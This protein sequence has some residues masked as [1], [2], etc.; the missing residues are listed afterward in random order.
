MIQAHISQSFLEDLATNAE[1]ECF[2]PLLKVTL[3]A[4]A[5]PI[6]ML[7]ECGTVMLVNTA[8]RTMAAMGGR[9][10]RGCHRGESYLAF[11]RTLADEI[12]GGLL[13]DGMRRLIGGRQ[14]SLEATCEVKRSGVRRMLRIQVHRVEQEMPARFVATHR[15]LEPPAMAEEVEERIAAA[16]AKERERL[17][18]ELHDSVGQHLV[19]LGLG[20]TQ[21]RRAAADHPELTAVIGEMAESLREAHKEVRTLSYVMYPPPREEGGFGAEAVSE[22]VTGFARRAGLAASV[23]VKG[24]P[25]ELDRSRELAL[26]RVLQEALVNIHRHARAG[27]VRV[28]LYRRGGKVRLT[29][30]DDGA[31]FGGDE[32]AGSPRSG[33]GLTAMHARMALLGGDLRI[34]SGPGGTTLTAELPLAPASPNRP[35]G[36]GNTTPPC[37]TLQ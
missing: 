31:G 22:F 6:A 19:C 28:Q 14:D 1:R 32:G 12:S 13:K 24:F 20:L 17:A 4:L 25:C 2:D 9:D 15:E 11:C 35:L 26:F 7:D 30:K 5:V 29:V 36:L 37:T 23:E 21:L 27:S 8:W 3:D 18:A 16:Q 33:V 34:A 10:F